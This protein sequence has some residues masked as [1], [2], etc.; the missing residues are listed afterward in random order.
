MRTSN[1]SA[2]S[3]YEK[4][5][6]KSSCTDLVARISPDILSKKSGDYYKQN[7]QKASLGSKF[8]KPDISKH[9]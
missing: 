4:E 5:R 1:A 2:L 7:V 3:K 9:E 8:A 6:N